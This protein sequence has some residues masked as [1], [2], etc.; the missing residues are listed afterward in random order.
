VTE[1]GRDA[2]AAGARR[3]A[4]PYSLAVGV[5]FLA[6]IV[7][8]GINAIN[9][10][11]FGLDPGDPL[12]KFAAPSATGSIDKDANVNPSKACSV[13]RRDAIRICDFFGRPLVVVAWFTKGCGTC[14]RQLDVV[15]AVRRRFPNVGFLGL[16]VRDSLENAQ[17]EVRTHNWRFP[18]AL[19]R[20][21]AVSG[22]LGVSGGPTIFFAYPGGVLMNK[23][24]GELDR[25]ALTRKV[26]ALV[27]VSRRRE[28][29][30]SPR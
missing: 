26:R 12:P 22:L 1:E 20:D 4:R 6:A 14:R 30:Q 27:E 13:P 29:T 5:L 8:A 11:S 16:D 15:E 21:G 17:K 2:D 23:F 3:A 7:I 10:K 25:A 24:L 28:R 9:H 18:M 19:D